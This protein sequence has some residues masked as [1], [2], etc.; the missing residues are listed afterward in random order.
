M[1]TMGQEEKGKNNNKGHEL[2][3]NIKGNNQINS[4]M[5]NTTFSF[6][7]KHDYMIPFGTDAGYPKIGTTR[8]LWS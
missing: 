2:S 7:I 5:V 6:V 4:I 1:D 3:Y 8:E